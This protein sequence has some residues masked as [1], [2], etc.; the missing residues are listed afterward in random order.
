MYRFV[1]IVSSNAC[2]DDDDDTY[3]CPI[4]NINDLVTMVTVR[5]RKYSRIFP[6]MLDHSENRQTDPCYSRLY[7]RGCFRTEKESKG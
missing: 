6:T 4:V 3:G 7:S 2:N 1:I 5:S